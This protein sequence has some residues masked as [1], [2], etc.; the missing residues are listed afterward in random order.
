[1]EYWQKKMK[2]RSLNEKEIEKYLQFVDMAYA[3]GM[4]TGGTRYNKY[5][6]AY[7]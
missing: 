3:A 7:K 1:M 2:S 5:E 6:K 4:I